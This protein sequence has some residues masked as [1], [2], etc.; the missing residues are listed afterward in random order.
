MPNPPPPGVVLLPNVD[1]PRPAGCAGWIPATAR[2]DVCVTGPFPDPVKVAC[3]CVLRPG[4]CEPPVGIVC[5]PNGMGTK[6]S[7]VIGSFQ[8]LRT[9]FCSTRSLRFGGYAPT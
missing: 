5:C 7:S 3:G 6:S 4:V 2:P 8:F 9:N 1:P